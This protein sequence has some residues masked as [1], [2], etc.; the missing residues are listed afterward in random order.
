MNTEPLTPKKKLVFVDDDE[1]TNI[2]AERFVKRMPYDTYTFT[3]TDEAREF[4]QSHDVFAIIADL[5]MPLTDGLTF[6]K[7]LDLSA[8][9]TKIRHLIIQ[10]GAMP[11]DSIR[12]AIA[13]LGYGLVLKDTLFQDESYLR[14]LLDT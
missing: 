5:R 11:E 12:E 8:E 14:S 2:L 9:S 3:D 13:T 10:S 4:I 1:F 6:L 7:S